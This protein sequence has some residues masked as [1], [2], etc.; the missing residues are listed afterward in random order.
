MSLKSS[1]AFTG[2]SFAGMAT[3]AILAGWC[4]DILIKRGWDPV[5]VRKGFTIAGL[6]VASTEVFGAMSDSN[7]VALAMSIISLSGLG[8]ATANYWALTQTLMPGAAIGRIAGVQ[9]CAS[10]LSGI[11]APILT[12]WLKAA[13]GSY[14]APM[15][16]IVVLLGLGIAA[17]VFLVR[18]EYAP[19][20]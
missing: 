18:Q 15:V 20:A 16:A 7:T 11:V 2:F 3:V 6:M 14:V 5:R 13:T 1:G 19:K 9:N 10:N 17:Y 8:L 4:A 12:G